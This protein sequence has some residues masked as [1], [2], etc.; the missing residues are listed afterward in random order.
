LTGVRIYTAKKKKKNRG[1]NKYVEGVANGLWASRRIG[2][3]DYKD[4]FLHENQPWMKKK[5]ESCK[6]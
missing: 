2:S 6:C 4:I 1:D 5:N 3:E